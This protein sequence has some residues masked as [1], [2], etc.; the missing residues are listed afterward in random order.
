MSAV[1]GL[2]PN[3]RDDGGPN[4]SVGGG[5][6]VACIADEENFIGRETFFRRVRSLNVLYLEGSVG[7]LF[8]G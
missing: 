7:V 1:V 6:G 8:G 2:L 5:G 4:L 3:R